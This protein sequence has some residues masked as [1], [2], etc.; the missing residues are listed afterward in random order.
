[1]GACLSTGCGMSTILGCLLLGF[2]CNVGKLQASFAFFPPNPP[3]YTF[4]E[5]GDGTGVLKYSEAELQTSAD[6]L[7]RECHSVRCFARRLIT[8]TGQSICVHHFDHSHSSVTFLW[9]HGNAEDLGLVFFVCAQLAQ[10][11]GVS[12][13]AYDYEGYGVSTGRPLEKSLC[14][15]ILCVYDYLI[16]SGLRANQIVLYGQSVGSGPSVWLATKRDVLALILH[17][18]LASGLRSLIPDGQLSCATM[19]GC[20]SPIYMFATCD[21]FPNF[22]RIA[23]VR[24]PTLLMHGTVDEVLDVSHT[25]QLHKNCPKEYRRDPYIVNGAGHDDLAEHDPKG[26]FAALQTFLDSLEPHTKSTV[27]S[28]HECASAPLQPEGHGA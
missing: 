5:S 28:P 16:E 14:R 2:R 27:H 7:L 26:Y 4:H 20:C 12:I 17:S 11:L 19:Q 24:C 21:M 3:S 13:V 9:S 6:A 1:M 10:R 18:P 22:K 25:M 8:P 23:R 15:D